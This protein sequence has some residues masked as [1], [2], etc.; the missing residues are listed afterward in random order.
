MKMFYDN[1]ANMELLRGKKITIVGYGSQG[2]AHAQNLRDSGMKVTVTSREGSANWKFAIE[3]GFKPKDDVGEAVK[4]ADVVMI[5]IPDQTQKAVYD[6][7][8]GPNLKKGAL[9]MFAH[10]FNIHFGQILPGKDIDVGMIAPKA[11]GHTVRSE[12]VRGAGTPCLLAIH[13]DASGKAREMCL[14]YAK[15]IGGTRAGV[16]ETTF[17]D[18][19]ETDLFGE[20]AVLCGGVS[21]LVKAGFDTLVEA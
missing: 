9:L 7:F 6:K 19:T 5:V 13:Q 10:G 4:G 17:R 8:I 12:Y 14:A 15:A 18:E 11:P 3:H 21:A 16:I 2:H 1:D 20:Q